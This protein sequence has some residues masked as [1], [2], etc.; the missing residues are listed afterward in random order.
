MNSSGAAEAEAEGGG[1]SLSVGEQARAG[2]RAGESGG[3]SLSLRWVCSAAA[4]CVLCVPPSREQG[5]GQDRAA[6]L[7]GFGN[8]RFHFSA[9]LVS[10]F[11]KIHFPSRIMPDSVK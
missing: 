1:F 9:G 11:E 5:R 7:S 2:C 3:C 6:A 10:D 8:R 4:A